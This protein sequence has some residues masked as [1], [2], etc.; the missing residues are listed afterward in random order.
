VRPLCSGTGPYDIVVFVIGHRGPN[1]QLF[2]ANWQDKAHDNFQSWARRS[3][4][5]LGVDAAASPWRRTPDVATAAEQ[6]IQPQ[7]S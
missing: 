3:N 5:S 1:G 2:S 4:L 7:S 6:C